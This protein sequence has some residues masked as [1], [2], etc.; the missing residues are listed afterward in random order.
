[1]NAEFGHKE[2]YSC[3]MV[4]FNSQMEMLYFKATVLW[5]FTISTKHYPS[6]AIAENPGD[7]GL[8]R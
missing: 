3:I 6:L 1:M 4:F 5:A 7:F 2:M 8:T